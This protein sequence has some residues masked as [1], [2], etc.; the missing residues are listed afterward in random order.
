MDRSFVYLAPFLFAWRSPFFLDHSP[1]R[2]LGFQVPFQVHETHDPP[3]RKLGFVGGA[4]LVSFQRQG[5]VDLVTRGW[6]GLKLGTLAGAQC[7][8]SWIQS[9]NRLQHAARSI[10][11]QKKSAVSQHLI[12]K[13]DMEN[14]E[15]EVKEEK[16]AAESKHRRFGNL[17]LYEMRTQVGFV[18]WCN[19]RGSPALMMDRPTQLP[20]RTRSLIWLRRVEKRKIGWWSCQ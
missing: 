7:L 18:Q 16:N 2:F 17:D 11:G 12:W 5:W 4:W 1:N 10:Q 19:E 20:F 8:W 13:V 3:D 14:V 15:Q 9:T 6:W